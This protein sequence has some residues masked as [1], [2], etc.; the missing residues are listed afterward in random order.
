MSVRCEGRSG[1][2]KKQRSG[3]HGIMGGHRGVR[4][5]RPPF[6]L[7]SIFKQQCTRCQSR[8]WLLV[9]GCDRI[10]GSDQERELATRSLSDAPGF[11]T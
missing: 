10:T 7:L 11:F 1:E 9:A 2:L 6:H 5:W 3:L 8:F 4:Q